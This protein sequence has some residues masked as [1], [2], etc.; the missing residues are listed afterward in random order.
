[1][2]WTSTLGQATWHIL[3]V[4]PP[5][6]K[7]MRMR[8]TS[9]YGQYACAAAALASRE[10]QTSCLDAT[11][12]AAWLALKLG[13]LSFWWNNQLSK[14]L[15]SRERRLHGVVGYLMVQVL[16]LS[17]RAS[18]LF[19][20]EHPD[21][22]PAEVP[23]KGVH[24][25]MLA[26]I[27]FITLISMTT[28]KL[29]VPRKPNLTDHHPVQVDPAAT[30]LAYQTHA[31]PVASQT[32]SFSASF[33]ISALSKT[34]KATT[35]P[36]LQMQV[37]QYEEEDN[38]MDWTP[39]GPSQYT[40][41]NHQPVPEYRRPDGPNPFRGTLPPAPKAPAHKARNPKPFLP[42]SQDK[43]QNFMNQIR[44]EIRGATGS[45]TSD[46]EDGAF[47]FGGSKKSNAGFML[48]PSNMRDY[49]A[50]SAASGLEDLFNSAF[51]INA[52]KPTQV[53]SDAQ[54]PK[55]EKE[56]GFVIDGE[57]VRE[58]VMVMRAATG[59]VAL[60]VLCF[61]LAVGMGW[62]NPKSAIESLLYEKEVVHE[63]HDVMEDLVEDYIGT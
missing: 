25:A 54:P 26:F 31:S 53:Q 57:T 3:G 52:A 19:M 2:W 7:Q 61:A 11:S 34:P 8:N 13:L 27:V 37:A 12:S 63:V 60:V 59:F 36:R 44:G 28:V 23:A 42:A 22:I 5:A 9:W 30:K 40:Q 21:W 29:Q 16:N 18:A 62:F 20:L 43:K 49:Q 45:P 33:P 10:M 24:G 15:Y 14:K 38:E 51:T 47:S 48:G 17:I 39:T 32:T 41:F 56:R 4:L 55:Q 50:E 1:M 6:Q 58:N 35:P 46:D